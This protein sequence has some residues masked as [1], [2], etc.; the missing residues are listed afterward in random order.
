MKLKLGWNHLTLNNVTST[1][2]KNLAFNLRTRY[3]NSCLNRLVLIDSVIRSGTVNFMVILWQNFIYFS[4]NFTTKGRRRN[5]EY[6]V[7][8]LHF[9]F[10]FLPFLMDFFMSQHLARL[11][12]LAWDLLLDHNGLKRVAALLSLLLWWVTGTCHH[13]HPISILQWDSSYPSLY[14]ASPNII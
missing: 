12:Q 13:A 1:T 14:S 11:L 10:C 3:G 9:L 7:L 4:D 8:L 6:T 2:S 5:S